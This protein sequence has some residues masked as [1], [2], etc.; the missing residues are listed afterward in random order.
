M[1]QLVEVPGVLKW[2]ASGCECKAVLTVCC[3]LFFFVQIR[4]FRTAVGEAGGQWK[5]AAGGCV[6]GWFLGSAFHC[7]RQKKA[8]QNKFKADQKALVRTALCT[9]LL[10]IWTTTMDPPSHKES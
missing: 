5:W 6:G 3:D 10:F 9:V 2:H 1:A 4:V 8:L 7:R